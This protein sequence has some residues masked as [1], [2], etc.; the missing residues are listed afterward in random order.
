[1]P[2]SA[3]R[4]QLLTQGIDLVGPVDRGCRGS[5]ND[6]CKANWIESLSHYDAQFL[7]V[8]DVKQNGSL[9][10]YLNGKQTM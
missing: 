4:G 7:H 6:W 3:A 1:M 10:Q 2:W 5:Q 9:N 8:V